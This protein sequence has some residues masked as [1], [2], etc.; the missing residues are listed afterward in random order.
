MSAGR[1]F[2]RLRFE[3]VGAVAVIGL[4]EPA[5][6]NA[7]SEALR[8]QLLVALD[9]AEADPGIAALV[10]RGEGGNFSSGAHLGEFGRARSVA[11]ARAVRRARNPY[12]RVLHLP[13]PVVAL[14]EGAAIGGGLELALSCDVRIATADALAGL[15]EVRRGFIPGGGGSQ[16]AGR[17][18]GAG[19]LAL[20]GCA[21]GADAA[22]RLGIF[23]ELYPDAAAARHR[24]LDLAARL[25]AGDGRR[26]ARAKALLLAS[27]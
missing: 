8:E 22:L 2:D 11:S 1:P 3:R 18:A 21:V 9:V 16:L 5:T 20:E 15:P 19:R 17:R 4:D 14:V 12:R 7:I 24:A 23:H 25:A 10:L 13:L 27:A 26:L 6:R